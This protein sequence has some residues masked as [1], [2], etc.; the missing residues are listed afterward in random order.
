MAQDKEI[1]T[2]LIIL[3]SENEDE[4]IFISN[5]AYE[6]NNQISFPIDAETTTVHKGTI[7]IIDEAEYHVEEITV[8][9]FKPESKVLQNNLQVI[10]FVNKVNA[11]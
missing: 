1:V 2:K 9:F 3:N 11:E 5:N 6:L 7:L 4:V 8:D 10:L